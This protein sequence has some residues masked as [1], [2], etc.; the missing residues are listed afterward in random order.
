[1]M[2][3][4]VRVTAWAGAV[5]G[6]VLLSLPFWGAQAAVVTKMN[7]QKT[8][9]VVSGPELEFA[10]IGDRIQIGENCEMVIDRKTQ[11]GDTRVGARTGDCR[12]RQALRVGATGA[13]IS[14]V[15]DEADLV[16]APSGQAV[17]QMKAQMRSRPQ[18]RLPRE[19][20]MNGFGVGVM[21]MNLNKDGI[22]KEVYENQ[23]RL[24]RNQALENENSSAGTAGLN[25]NYSYVPR[26]GIGV[27][28]DLSFAQVKKMISEDGYPFVRPA[29]SLA[30]GFRDHFYLSGGANYMK[31]L[32]DPKYVA[33]TFEGQ[34]I[35]IKPE[36]GWQVGGGFVWNDTWQ[37]Q[38]LYT[39][40]S[41]KMDQ[42]LE[43]GE[44]VYNPDNATARVAG[45]YSFTGLELTL[46]YRF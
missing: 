26:S 27:I 17:A 44:E 42:D 8:R 20:M 12:D 14:V 13:L 18:I 19:E 33:G 43:I 9:V 28:A 45:E 38:L 29:V 40:S 2:I 10:R 15:G 24:T 35:E 41:Q 3:R 37:A 46:Q 4:I 36:V 34:T 11:E 21:A 32:A 23:Y 6:L 22:A 31:F 39:Q 1:M 30:L 16:A 25:L 7:A 5:T